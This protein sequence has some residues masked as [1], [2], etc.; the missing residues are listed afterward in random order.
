M[1]MITTI[2][3]SSLVIASQR[4]EAGAAPPGCLGQGALMVDRIEPE[5]GSSF[6]GGTLL[7]RRGRAGSEQAQPDELAAASGER[8]PRGAAHG[9]GCFQCANSP[10]QA[11]LFTLSEIKTLIR[12]ASRMGTKAAARKVPK[13]NRSRRKGTASTSA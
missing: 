5:P 11:R 13:L 1:T 2:D 12:P 9:A 10:R 7:D 4:G 6:M 3:T 8:Q